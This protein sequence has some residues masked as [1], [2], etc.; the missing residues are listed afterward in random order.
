[1]TGV[2]AIDFANA[3]DGQGSNVV[4]SADANL[5]VDASWDGV[6]KVRDIRT[7]RVDREFR[8]PGEMITELSSSTNGQTWAFLHQPRTKAGE[9]FPAPPYVSVWRWPLSCPHIIE[10]ALD[11]AHSAVIS[12][13]GLSIAVAGYCRASQQT[14]LR[15]LDIAGKLLV[16]CPVDEGR[17]LRWS[18]CGTLIGRVG[19]SDIAVHLSMNL[20]QSHTFEIEYPSAVA[21]APDL[22]FIALGSWNGGVVQSFAQ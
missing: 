6:I 19:R 5:L 4:F 16:E 3:A 22:S 9:N 10:L 21:F 14:F 13:D 7:G 12:P 11:G 17:R 20:T 18:P 1:M 15:R 8:Y 2:T